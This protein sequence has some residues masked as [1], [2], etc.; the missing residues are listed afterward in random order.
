MKKSGAFAALAVALLVMVVLLTQS[1]WAPDT[2]PVDIGKITGLEKTGKV[3]LNFGYSSGRTILPPSPTLT[4][5]EL[6]FTPISSGVALP[7]ITLVVGTDPVYPF[8]TIDLAAG[9]YTLTVTGFNN[10]TPTP[11]PVAVATTEE[12]E[13]G[14][15]TTTRPLEPENVG[16]PIP[17]GFTII[18]EDTTVIT[19]VLKP[20]TPGTGGHAGTFGWNVTTTGVTGANVR[21]LTLRTYP[22]GATITEQPV[23]LLGTTPTSSRP[24]DTGYYWVDVDIGTSTGGTLAFR[25]LVHVYRNMTSTFTRTFTNDNL[26]LA[27]PGEGDGSITYVHVAE[28]NFDYA[29][30]SAGGVTVVGTGSDVTSN[31]ILLSISNVGAIDNVTITPVVDTGEGDTYSWTYGMNTPLGTA[32][33]PLAIDLKS[34]PYTLAPFNLPTADLP[35]TLQGVIGGV[36]FTT[37]IHLKITL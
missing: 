5:Y 37:I 36:P 33:T 17:A 13:A 14:G 28:Y 11:L 19:V 20:F 35:I 8:E 31:P 27:K 12:D 1:C 26:Y 22:G 10:A 9:D 18:G 4:R 32:N 29:L 15:I 3:R 2:G 24:I 7:T 21:N 25:D 30:S 6:V 34:S 16:D 23:I